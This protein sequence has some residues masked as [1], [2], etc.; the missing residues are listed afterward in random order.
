MK[1]LKRLAMLIAICL[2]AVYGFVQSGI[3]NVAATN[4][5]GLLI[6][7]LLHTTMEK[8]VERRAQDI[9]VPDIE[10]NK[11]ILAGLSDYVEMCAQCHGEPNKPSG[12]LAQGLNPAPTNL[13]YLAEAG[14][15]AE[16]FWVINNGIRMT[17]MAAFGK[18]HQADEIWPVI[19]FLQSAKNIT[20]SEYSQ[21]KKEAEA[22]GHHKAESGVDDKDS[23]HHSDGANVDHSDHDADTPSVMLSDD[24]T[25]EMPSLKQKEGN[26]G[27][28][29]SHGE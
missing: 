3:F 13:E 11:M 8:S 28:Q 2:I 29:H 5:D 23:D 16:M 7:W 19:A 20:S 14:T 10:N 21:M 9:E 12:Y 24:K 22:Y 4:K 26:H 25:S 15:A 1:L 6:T 18:T 27:H 17:G